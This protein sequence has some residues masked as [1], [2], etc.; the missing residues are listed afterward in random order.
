MGPSA[1]PLTSCVVL[2]LSYCDM[3]A[4]LSSYQHTTATPIGFI[5]YTYYPLFIMDTINTT[6]FFLQLVDK[7]NMHHVVR[8]VL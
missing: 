3:I 1:A 7:A 2:V 5:H 6:T 8:T 4:F